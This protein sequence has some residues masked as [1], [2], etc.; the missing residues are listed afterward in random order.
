MGV[1]CNVSFGGSHTEELTVSNTNWASLT[2]GGAFGTSVWRV[3]TSSAPTTA[4]A[5]GTQ[6]SRGYLRTETP[7]SK[8]QNV[9]AT[10]RKLGSSVL[11]DQFVFVAARVSPTGDDYIS[12]SYIESL[13]GNTTGHVRITKCVNGT[14]TDVLTVSGVGSMAANDQRDLE[15]R[16]SGSAPNISASVW[17]NGVQQGATQTLTE[18]EL[19]TVGQVGMFNRVNAATAAIGTH[20]LQFYA[21]DDTSSSD[22]TPPT[23]TGPSGATGATSAINV[24]ENASAVFTFTANE[25]VTWS[26]NGGADVARFAI[27]AGGALSFLAAPNFEAPNDADTNNTYVV[28]VRATDTAGNATTQTCTVTVTNVNEG[29]SI[30]SLG[31]GATGAVSVAENTTAVVTCTATDPDAGA[32][33]TWSIIG[34]ADAARFTIGSSSG[35]LAFAAAPDF[36]A[37]TDVGA[38]NVYD[39]IVQVS[40]GTLLDSQSI[41]VTVTDV[42]EGGGPPP[43]AAGFD[44]HTAAGLVFG[45]LSGSLTGLAREVGVSITPRVYNASTGALVTALPATATDAAGRLPRMTHASLAAGTSYQVTFVWPDG[46]V[47]AVTLPAT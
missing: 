42:T 32:A 7:G 34:G 13:S 24:A 21:E 15:L 23:L 31:G 8:N 16:V 1:I 19:D 5:D 46:A 14:R 22:T 44:F 3:Q 27:G 29:P 37:P 12:A 10:L 4:Y 2:T 38:N 20:V 41:A 28:G 39:V 30:T 47:Y 17:F 11:S 35:V 43:P 6:P 26:L 45:A 33:L 36:E 40:D 25:T 18:A 9:R